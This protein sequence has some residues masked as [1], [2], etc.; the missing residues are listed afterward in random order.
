LFRFIGFMLK[1]VPSLY[2]V[3]KLIAFVRT[4]FINIPFLL[5]LIILYG[6]PFTTFIGVILY[7]TIFKDGLE[8]QLAKEAD[9]N[10]S[11]KYTGKIQLRRMIRKYSLL[12]LLGIIGALLFVFYKPSIILLSIKIGIIFSC[13]LFGELFRIVDIMIQENRRN[14]ATLGLKKVDTKKEDD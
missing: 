12:T 7:F 9:E 1:I 4:S 5:K 14:N 6:I 2:F 13:F 3:T 11:Q 10:E 8:R